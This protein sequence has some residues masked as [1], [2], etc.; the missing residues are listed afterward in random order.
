MTTATPSCTTVTTNTVRV[1][2][3]GGKE[4]I[5]S[6]SLFAPI[7]RE[8]DSVVTVLVDRTEVSLSRVTGYE[9]GAYKAGYVTE[10]AK[11]RG[12]CKIAGYLTLG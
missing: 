7:V 1:I 4:P 10:E 5:A 6:R 11:S 8:I 2:R 3:V 9:V 12:Y